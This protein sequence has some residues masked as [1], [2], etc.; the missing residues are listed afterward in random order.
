MYIY[1]AHEIKEIDAQAEERGFSTFTL[2]ENAGQAIFH[3][4]KNKIHKE[5]KIAILAGKGNNGGDGT[6]LARLLKTHGYQV[7]LL[8]PLGL[9][10]TVCAKQ[11]LV[12]LKNLGFMYTK[13]VQDYDVIV[14]ALLGIGVRLPLRENAQKWIEWINTQS[15][16]KVSID[17][18]SGVLSDFGQVEMAVQANFTFC[19]HGLKPS[20]LL[21][22]SMDFYG[23]KE[24]LSIGLPHHSLWKCWTEEDIS[25]TFFQRKENTHK[26]SFGTGLLLAG[27]DEMPG[28]AILAS[29]AAMRAGI[30]KLTVGTSRFVAQCIAT[31]LAECSY[32]L[33][34]WKQP[35]DREKINAYEAIAIGPGLD[36]LENLEAVIACLLKIQKPLIL[37]AAAL[38]QRIYPVRKEPIVLTPHPKEMSRI[39]GLPVKAIQSNRL[40]VALDYAIKHHVIIVLKGRK[41]VCAFP[42]G[43]VNVIETGNAGLAKGGS[44]D[45]LTGILLGFL[46]YYEDIEAA[47]CNAVYLHGLCA[48]ICAENYAKSAMFASDFIELLP[49]AMKRFEKNI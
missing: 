5:M 15:A 49:K 30:G 22:N 25:R 2:M 44:G 20:A 42:N 46:S 23:E 19:L 35:L 16:Y 21:E 28:C 37:D 10:E 24:I 48:D 26:G 11:H 17:L 12:Y 40:Q 3:A 13:D 39:T 32:M 45:T 14:D 1:K 18:P 33:D 29:Q 6:V 4:L 8:F 47:V 31:H 34:V 41:T 36:T 7:D 9:P 27:T 38:Q 43:K